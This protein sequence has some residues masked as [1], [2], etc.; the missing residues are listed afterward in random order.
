MFQ[1]L[2]AIDSVRREVSLNI[3]QKNK[4]ELGQ[5]FTPLNIVLSWRPCF[6]KVAFNPVIYWMRAQVWVRYPVHSLIGG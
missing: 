5:F 4:S 3:D 1:Q 6:Q 2:E